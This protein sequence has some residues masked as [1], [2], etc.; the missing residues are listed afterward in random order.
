[1]KQVS[2]SVIVPVF[3]ERYLVEESLKRLTVLGRCPWIR[4]VQVI[5]VDDCSTDGSRG[6]LDGLA[7]RLKG[8]GGKMR[9]VFLRHSKNAGKGA[10][11]RTALAQAVEEICIIH[12]AD[13]EYHPEDIPDLLLPF[14]EDHADAVY[15][16]RFRPKR[17]SRALFYR[18]ALG[19]NLLT[20]LSNLLSN[21]NLTDMET[22]YKAVRTD[23]LKSIPL[24]SDDFR[25]EVELTLKLAK[26]GARLFEAPITYSGRTYQ[27]GK[28]INW[29]DGFRALAA[30]LRFA[31][32]DK[33]YP[34]DDHGS[35]ILA[36]L[37]RA[38]RFNRW[39]SDR[40]KPY[41]GTRVL[42]I[43]AGIGNMTQTLLPRDL[44]WT[45]D[46]NP[47]YLPSLQALSLNKP[48]LHAAYCDV[49]RP[50]SF[51]KPKGGFDTAV[52]LNVM[53]HVEDDAQVMSALAGALGPGGRAVVLVPQ[54]QWAFGSLDK[55]LG[56]V[57]R[58]DAKRLRSLC[59]G[60]GL[61]VEALFG[62]NRIGVPAWVLNGLLLRRRHFGLFQ[63][64]L[65]NALTP[66]F[67]L[68]DR[69]LPWPSLSL[70]LVA[71]KPGRR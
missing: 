55:V 56:H 30:M 24:E 16:S 40:I 61:E 33:I 4:R 32:S 10:A 65:L 3:N 51:P 7:R 17:Y 18:H 59:Q 12:D 27:E 45:T 25:L 44:Y 54:G 50:E 46:I 5:V 52:C 66:L 70:I 6:I 69:W 21:Y 42:E 35:R 26:R 47:Y 2:L 49:T 57:R 41:V 23:L 43:G 34:D 19:N 11:V 60:A 53:E 28:K 38:P 62:F 36:R 71:R 20:F 1:M 64:M 37:S 31:V 14:I 8:R 67:R 58:Y 68:I 63:V 15:G 29:K 22:C 48:Y 9:W 13:L 39:M